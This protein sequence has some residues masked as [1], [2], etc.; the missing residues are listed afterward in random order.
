MKRLRDNGSY[1]HILKYTG[2]FG[3]VQLLT[4]LIGLVRNKVAAV[5]LGPVGMG[6]MALFNSAT[7]FG[8]QAT[9]LGLPFSAVRH[10]SEEFES[11]DAASAARYVAVVRLW[12][13]VTAV[14]GTL[15]FAMFG[16]LLSDTVF[17][18]GDHTLHF[19]LLSPVVGMMALTGSETAILKGTRQ[20]RSLASIQIWSVVAALIVS[21]PV[22]W[23]FGVSGIV[24]V[25][26]LC[27][28]CTM[29]LTMRRSLRLYPFRIC[30]DIWRTLVSGIDMVKLGVSFVFASILGSGAELVVR[31]FLNVAGDLD[32]VGLYNAG[33][34][35][36]ATYAGMVFS[37]METDYF[38]R[39]SAVNH[40]NRAVRVLVNR[41]VEVSLLLLSPMLVALMV[42]IPLLL[43]ILYSG[44]FMAVVSMAQVAVLAMYFKAVT[45]PLAYINLAKGNSRDYILLEGAYAFYFVPLIMVFYDYWGLYGTGVAMTVA[46]LIEMLSIAVFAHFKYGYTMSLSVVKNM[47][48]QYLL[49]G[50]T[51]AVTLALT[52][53]G[54]WSCGLLLMGAS[55]ALSLRIISRKTELWNAIKGKF[56]KK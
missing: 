40:D 35:L 7:N 19:V 49:G 46:N 9:G 39:L 16:P 32:T 53:W 26:V 48:A 13:I 12:S 29:A 50:L 36:T 18:W 4:I 52:G 33:Y 11:G 51:Y 25:L 55:A 43:P 6:L 31:S 3:S 17:S 34:I 54:Y 15:L 10:L 56:V 41:Q 1:G 47:A 5:L 38:P 23:F 20:L 42:F 14:A 30:G 44:K 27:A 45:S 28:F 37:A 2:L 8:S 22:Y 24:P 21:V